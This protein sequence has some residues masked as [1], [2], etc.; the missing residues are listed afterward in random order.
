MLLFFALRSSGPAGGGRRLRG[1]SGPGRLHLAEARKRRQEQGNVPRPGPEVSGR[2]RGR[3][4]GAAKEVLHS[5]VAEAALGTGRVRRQPDALLIGAQGGAVPGTELG[6]GGSSGAGE[7]FLRGADGRRRGLQ[8]SIRVRRANCRGHRLGVE[9]SKGGG[10]GAGRE[11]AVH[12]VVFD[13]REEAGLGW[14]TGGR[15]GGN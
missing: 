1:W 7:E 12:Q 8:D 13:T 14:S 9:G 5:V 3:V 2:E 4:D 6:K 15:D 10:V 11:G